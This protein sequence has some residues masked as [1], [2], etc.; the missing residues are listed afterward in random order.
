[1]PP[2][3][4]TMKTL[5]WA[6]LPG[7]LGL[8]LVGCGSSGAAESSPGGTG[9]Q[10]ELEFD[11]ATQRVAEDA[12]PATIALSLSRALAVDLAVSFAISGTALDGADFTIDPGPLVIPAG[13]LQALLTLTP[14]V[15]GA[16]EA[17]ETVILT[18]VSAQGVTLGGGV[19]HTVGL[20]D[21][22]TEIMV[23]SE[24][25]DG[26]ATAN[27][28]GLAAL[29]R[30][31]E[32]RGNIREGFPDP[33]DVFEFGTG[34]AVVVSLELRPGSQQMDLLLFVTDATGALILPPVQNVGPGA[35][36]TI[37]F[38]VDPG[39]M[40]EFNLSISSFGPPGDYELRMEVSAPPLSP[41]TSLVEPWTVDW[42]ELKETLRPG[43]ASETPRAHRRPVG[44]GIRLDVSSGRVCPGLLVS[45][46]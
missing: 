23:E 1:M 34:P 2:A 18:L 4:T 33:F 26:V 24:P 21:V 31:L 25:N 6:W 20:E 35:V 46:S 44:T 40:P 30:C 22:D 9:G 42:A 28:A 41:Q 14:I 10:V 17:S 15:D 19:V 3:S 5:R 38:A 43:R 37:S 8:G 7:L 11:R 39:T 29:G 36:E 45:R 32:I 27:A 12:G 16:C 13:D